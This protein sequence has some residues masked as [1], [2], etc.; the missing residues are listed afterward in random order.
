MFLIEYSTKRGDF[1]DV[2]NELLENIKIERENENKEQFITRGKS[3]VKKILYR[4]F[5]IKCT[6]KIK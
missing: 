4:K 3:I 5:N 2:F 6:N 1:M